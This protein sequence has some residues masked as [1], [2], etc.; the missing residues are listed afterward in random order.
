MEFSDFDF[1]H[2]S[3]I[4]HRLVNLPRAQRDVHY[5][6][7]NKL[8]KLA[9]TLPPLIQVNSHLPWKEIKPMVCFPKV[10]QQLTSMI[11]QDNYATVTDMYTYL[12]LG[13]LPPELKKL[14]IFLKN[15]NG[16]MII[17]M[18]ELKTNRIILR[19]VPKPLIQVLKFCKASLPMTDQRIFDMSE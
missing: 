2:Q 11:S 1:V 18:K 12:C 8:R 15:G 7:F 17:R 10:I 9:P 6:Y 5:R 13:L 3:R 4:V 16:A 19:Y 14:R